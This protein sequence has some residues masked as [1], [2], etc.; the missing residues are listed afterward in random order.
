MNTAVLVTFGLS[1]VGAIAI[2]LA[3]ARAVRFS[4]WIA[5]AAPAA[6][7]WSGLS[8]L[9]GA[10]PGGT[11]GAPYIGEAVVVSV[12]WLS[13][14]D[15]GIGVGLAVD[16]LA[17]A[18]LIVVGVV[19]A[20]VVLFSF[21]YM[22]EDRAQAR[23]FSLLSL[24][25]GAMAALVTSSSLVGLFIAWEI[26][27][28]CSYLLIGFWYTR[29]SAANAAMKAF[30]V[31]RL[32]D[33]GLLAGLAVLYHETHT[34][35]L[36][37][38]MAAVPDLA[39]PTVA[40]VALLLF[41]GAAGK[42]AQFPLHVWLPDA[43]EGP[44][45]VS[46]LI[47]AATMVAAG[48][49]LVA[50]TWPIFEAAEGTRLL[51]LAIGVIT[52]A[53]ASV[54]ALL[55]TDIKKVLA[56][57]TISQLGFMFAALG[58]GAWVAAVFH[59][60]THAAFKSL[61]FLAAGSVIHGSGTQDLR[62]MGG[63]RRAMPVTSATWIVGAAALAGLPPLSGFFSKDAI[64]EAVWHATPLAG[65]ALFA[66]GAVTTCYITRATRLAFCGTFRGSARPHE[67]GA[68]MWLPLVVL[69]LGAASLGA[70]SGE[71]ARAFGGHGGLS[72]PVAAASIALAVAGGLVGW[73][74]GETGARRAQSGVAA[75]VAGGWGVDAAVVR[76]A[77]A[78]VVASAALSERVDAGI[79]DGAVRAVERLAQGISGELE[80][81]QSGDG[82]AYSGLVAIG[83]VL[84][85]GLTLWLGR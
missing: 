2:A 44:T 49:F 42:S 20:M 26:V 62:E 55:Q 16:S 81:L 82:R 3:G 73:R 80:G 19:A 59:L 27:G 52:A 48:V 65:A 50:R 9:L 14:A 45:P 57:S 15:A 23:Y 13:R 1:I 63:L 34:L 36:A 6:A 11:G 30:L 66:A 78:S 28:A 64:L 60:V 21:G 67:S 43:M 69:A 58:A 68:T 22:A 77:G 75:F 7:A 31:T 4:R 46:A 39:G 32:G 29:K 84:V 76:L 37:S 61:L 40:L 54:S 72:L 5:L 53:G 18:M 70:A 10:G 17:A 47:H 71:F 41:A 38:V 79:I 35:D 83:A 25:T 85:V 33:V 51:I 74:L 56:Y 12:R 8:Y 24:F